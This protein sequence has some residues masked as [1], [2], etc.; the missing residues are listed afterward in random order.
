MRVVKF[1]KDQFL[2]GFSFYSRGEIAGFQDAFADQ[3]I[4]A[5]VCAL[6]GDGIPRDANGHIVVAKSG[7][8]RAKELLGEAA[9]KLKV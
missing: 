9:E 2:P 4:K 7:F 5:G 1:L 3:M 6:E 8:A